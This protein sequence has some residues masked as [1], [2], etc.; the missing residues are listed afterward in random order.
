MCSPGAPTSQRHGHRVGKGTCE[1]EESSFPEDGDDVKHR[2][3]CPYG[4]GWV[5]ITSGNLGNKC[6]LKKKKNATSSQMRPKSV[7]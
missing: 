6:A 2:E 4:V 1:V 5:E 3:W 7:W